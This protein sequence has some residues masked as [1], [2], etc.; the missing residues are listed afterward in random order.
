VK[1]PFQIVVAV[2][3]HR[4]GV[5]PPAVDD[6]RDRR[7]RLLHEFQTRVSSLDEGIAADVAGVEAFTAAAVAALDRPM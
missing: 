4:I 3:A 1:R 5:H 6:A 7:D 2:D